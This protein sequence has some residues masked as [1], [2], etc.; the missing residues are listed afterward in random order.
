LDYS[1]GRAGTQDAKVRQ[2]RIDRLANISYE[3]LLQTR[4]VFGS[5]EHVRDRLVQF[6]EM[7]GITGITA[8]LNPGGFLPKEAVRRSLKLLT[9]EVMP[10]FK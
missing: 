4:V 9:Q 6:Q 1:R 10:A 7:L 8:E 5:P 3:D 2:A